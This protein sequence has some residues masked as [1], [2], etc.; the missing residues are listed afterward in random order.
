VAEIIKQAD[1]VKYIGDMIANVEL[2]LS[3]S[4]S[5]ILE[6]S[7]VFDDRDIS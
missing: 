3:T 6:A 7:K 5:K 1:E 4:K 2:K